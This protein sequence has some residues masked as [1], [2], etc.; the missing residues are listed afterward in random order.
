MLPNVKTVQ[1]GILRKKFLFTVYFPSCSLP[2]LEDNQLHCVLDYFSCFCFFQFCLVLFCKISKGTYILII[3][4]I[5]YIKYSLCSFVCHCFPLTPYPEN[6]SIS[7]PGDHSH[8]IFSSCIV[9]LCIYVLQA[10]QSLSMLGHLDSFQNCKITNI[11]VM[12]NLCICTFVLLE[13]YAR[14]NS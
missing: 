11:A 4:L 12:N 5:S 13:V 10:I 2:L 9:I 1:K 3:F 7:V 8:T 14:V 6:H